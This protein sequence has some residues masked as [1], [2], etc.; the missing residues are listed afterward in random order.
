L[1]KAPEPKLVLNLKDVDY[2]D[3]TGL[4]ALVL[5]ATTLKNAG[6]AVRLLNPDKRTMEL[7]VM[8]KLSAVFDTYTDEQDAVNSFFP[9]RQVQKFDILAFVKSQTGK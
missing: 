6:G 2:I 8:T 9:G 7:L 4:G 3:S 1:A 5:T